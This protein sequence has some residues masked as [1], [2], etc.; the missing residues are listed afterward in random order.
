MKIH[1][2]PR[3]AKF[4]RCD[5]YANEITLFKGGEEINTEQLSCQSKTTNQLLAQKYDV[6]KNT[7]NHF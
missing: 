4:E 5:I 3:E 7:S 1:L 6:S 2:L